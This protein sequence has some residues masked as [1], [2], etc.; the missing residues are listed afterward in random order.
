[1]N[2]RNDNLATTNIA[3]ITE[4]HTTGSCLVSEQLP[5]GRCIAALFIKRAAYG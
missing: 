3:K 4:E 5:M 2:K 1:M